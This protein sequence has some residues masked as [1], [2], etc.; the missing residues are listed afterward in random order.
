MN[1]K[2]INTYHSPERNWTLHCGDV[3][4][5]LPT[6]SPNSFSGAFCDPPYGLNFM[7]KDWDQAVPST[8]IWE[9]VLRLCKPGAY[10]LAFGG[11]RTFHRMVCNI[12]DAGWEIRDT[13]CW[14]YGEGFPK[15]QDISKGID[16]QLGLDRPVVGEKPNPHRG[17]NADHQYGFSQTGSMIPLTEAV[18]DEAKRWGGYS[19]ALKPAWEPII[20]AQKPRRGTFAA[21]SLRF[22]CG[23]INVDGCRIQGRWPANLLLDEHSAACLDEQS[24]HSR[25]QRSRRRKAGSNIGNGNTLHTF[26]SRHD[27][28]EGYSDSGGASRFF[29]VAKAKG[30][31]R[32][33]NDHPTLKPLA[34]CE[35]MAKLILPPAGRTPRRL[36]V[37]F[38]GV[39]SEMIGGLM[40]GWDHVTGIEHNAQYVADA[41]SRLTTH[42]S[43]FSV[44]FVPDTTTAARHE[45]I[46]LN[47]VTQGNC[48]DLIPRLPDDSVDVV[49]TSPPY[50]DQRKKHY[51]GVPAE[52]YATFTVDWM[53]RLA[54]KLKCN[55]SVLIVIRPDLKKGVINDYVLQ[56][57][58]ALR[59]AGW[60]E[61][62]ELIWLKRDGGACM[63][64]SKRP[65][66]CYE[67]ILWFSQGP[68]P[69]VDVKACGHWSDNVSIRAT[70]PEGK[71]FKE[72][73]GSG[74]TKLPDV[75]DVPVRRNPRGVDH[76]AMF[77]PE[78]AET[79]IKSFCPLRGVVLDPFAGSGN[80]CLAARNCGRDFYGFEIMAKYCELARKRL[81]DQGSTE[82][83]AG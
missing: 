42:S 64:S 29:Y 14:L 75:I 56:T 55:G 61:C 71:Q 22:G 8:A 21:N 4:H 65:R 69:F 35:Y 70:C 11:T 9:Q 72:I 3:Q 46:S 78:L 54:P 49:V 52:E 50:A 32:E 16:K 5:T 63:G 34:L 48:R 12:E 44:S 45:P 59:N 6:L 81:N 18:S 67:H 53:A 20:L 41:R 30:E 38:S 25:S 40:A 17:S 36:L 62:E 1:R 10:L 2:T 19:T 58:L 28:V 39:A 7:E 47:A 27:C 80:T 15:G 24:G 37:P 51:P 26:R 79:L 66:R 13:C 31:E 23:G 83:Q 43:K 73:R 74:R 77:P 33:G 76:P 68:D 82:S 57:R 60:H